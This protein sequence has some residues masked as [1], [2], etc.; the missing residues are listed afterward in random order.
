MDKFP[1]SHEAEVFYNLAAAFL[2]SINR[3]FPKSEA[4]KQKHSQVDEMDTVDADEMNDFVREFAVWQ[5]NRASSSS[6]RDILEPF[7][8]PKGSTRRLQ[9]PANGH[10]NRGQDSQ[11]LL[12]TR[13]AQKLAGRSLFTATDGYMGLAPLG[14]TTGDRLCI[15]LGC[16]VPL[17]I[18]PQGQR[19][20]LVGS[21]YMYGMMHGEIMEDVKAGKRQVETIELTYYI[22]AVVPIVGFGAVI[23]N[24][25]YANQGGI[26]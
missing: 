12:H 18:R 2:Y 20:L 15:L 16:E 17:V 4:G 10:R 19:Y 7:L 6:E 24:K 11:L 8:G 1:S 14:T 23:T 5:G 9:W 25:M 26:D 3:I 21:C 13:T 22:D